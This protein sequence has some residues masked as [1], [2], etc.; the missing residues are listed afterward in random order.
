MRRLLLSQL[1]EVC[2][3]FPSHVLVAGTVPRLILIRWCG[4]VVDSGGS[5]CPR[6]SIMKIDNLSELDTMARVQT[7]LA[8]VPNYIHTVVLRNMTIQRI[9][10]DVTQRRALHNTLVLHNRTSH[11]SLLRLQNTVSERVIQR[12]SI[13]IKILAI[14]TVLEGVA[15]EWIV[16]EQNDSLLLSCLFQARVIRPTDPSPVIALAAHS[17]LQ[18]LPVALPLPLRMIRVLGSLP[19]PHLN[20]DSEIWGFPRQLS[21]LQRLP[22]VGEAGPHVSESNVHL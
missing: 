22:L 12:K 19:T 18:P 11:S 1:R 6:Q 17:R 15:H 4:I 9:Q 2:T 16:G 5:R 14:Q 21:H 8:S 20:Q 7:I 3:F 13:K 10:H